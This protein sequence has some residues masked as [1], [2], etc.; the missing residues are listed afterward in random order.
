MQSIRSVLIL[1]FLAFCATFQSAQASSEIQNVLPSFTVDATEG[2]QASG[3]VVHFTNTSI[4]VDETCGVP[5][6]YAWT[7]DNGA[8]GVDW[9]LVEGTTGTSTDLAVEF[10]TQGCYNVQLVASDCNNVASSAPTEITVAGPPEIFVDDFTAFST[11]SNGLAEALWQMASNNNNTINFNVFIDGA[12]LWSNTY[13]GLSFCTDPGTIFFADVV[14]AGFLQPGMHQLIFQA[15]GDLYTIPTVEIVDFEVFEAPTLSATTSASAFCSYEQATVQANID[16]GL[17]PYVVDWS[18]DGLSQHTE[19]VTGNSSSYSFDLNGISGATNILVNLVDANGCSTSELIPIE[20]YEDVDFTVTTS[21]TCEGAPAEFIVTGN[22]SQYSWPSGIFSV[23][24]PVI[25]SDGTDTQSAVMG[26]GIAVDVLGEIV[27]TGTLDGDLT[28]SSIETA[29]AIVEVTPVLSIS[30]A[31]GTT[32][33]GNE[34]PEITVT[35]ADTYVWSPSPATQNG[36]I[37]TFP[38]NLASPLSGSATGTIDYAD[39]SCSSSILFNYEILEDPEVVL[40][41]DRD[42]LCGP[43]DVSMVSTGGMDPATYS[44]Q[45]WLNGFPITGET[46]NDVAVTLNYPDDAGVNNVACQVTHNN[47]CV[48][49][50]VVQIEML[51]GASISLDAPIICEADTF[52]VDVVA[53]GNVFWSANGSTNTATGIYYYPVNNGDSYTGTAT[54]T[55]PSVILGTDYNCSAD[56]TVVVETRALPDL[57]F[58]FSGTPCT[59]QSVQIDISGAQ[60]YTWTSDPNETNSTSNPDGAN[61][62]LNILSLGYTNAIPGDLEVNATGSITYTDANDIVCYTNE[63]FTQT[64]NSNTSFQLTGDTEI[65]EG[66]CINLTI[67][68]DEDP[69]GAT[70]SYDWYLDGILHSNGATFTECPT[71]ASGTAEVSLVVEAGNACQSNQIIQVN[72][73]QNPVVTATADV[74]E[75]CTPLIV[76]FTATNQFASVTAW[77][78]GNGESDTGVDNTQ[79]TFDCGDFDNGDCLYQVSYTAISPSNPNCTASEFIPITVH[80]IPVSEF[81]LEETVVC[82]DENNDTV[83]EVNNTSSELLGQTCA[84]VNTPYNWTLFPVGSGD[85]TETVDEQPTLTAAGTGTFT[86]G[87]EVTDAFGCSSQSFQ[88]FLVAEAPTPEIGFFSTSVCLPTQV[89][90]LNTTTGAATFELEVPGFVIP[91]NFNSPFYLD[92]EYPGVYEAEFTVTSIEGCSVTLEID[93][94]FEAWYPPTAAFTTDPVQIDVLEPFANFV[95]QSIGGT[96]FIWSFGDGDGSSEVN[97]VHEYYAAGEYDVQLHV[98]N[99]YGCTDVAT[100]TINISNLLQIFV[101]NSFTPN[102]DGNNDAWIPVVSGTELIAQYECWVYDRWGKLVFFSTTPGE[103]WVGD[104][105]IDGAGTH[106]VSSTEAFSWRI[107]IKMVDGLGARTQTGHVYLVR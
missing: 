18:I 98:T 19:T 44:F 75:G 53:N 26:N 40:S 97:P 20:V 5:V 23:S 94:A 95:N 92:I 71:Y 9:I 54:V 10:I 6:S 17:A 83:I 34:I 52:F 90:I 43:S 72:T 2:V 87:L 11:C 48:G 104:N 106:Y 24:N 31:P 57:D 59:G 61:P 65:C 101:P 15:Q 84:D 29:N 100:E 88:D 76:N 96:E 63:S 28:C 21:A 70:F 80:P 33:C 8:M 7:I 103:P 1:G 105:T 58:V 60:D 64:I 36:G 77:N 67:D 74:D 39:V 12:P 89:E 14:S 93:E 68:W 51:E 41:V 50:S 32:F 49:G 91:Q 3:F 46:G 30:P 47:G 78:Y 66:E 62:G 38:P 81:T 85:C 56:Q 25:T 22:A 69:N 73:T 86:V 99:E 4:N 42:V 55:S 13:Q 27:Y 102:N 37:A 35:G 79:M 16:F 107:E 82:F 45:W